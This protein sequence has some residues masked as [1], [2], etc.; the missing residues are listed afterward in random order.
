M[1][2]PCK[3][4]HQT[5]GLCL[6]IYIVSKMVQGFKVLSLTSIIAIS[7]MNLSACSP[8]IT[9]RGYIPSQEKLE[10][11][12]K[13]QDNKQTV[14][15]RLG[16]PSLT[17]SFDDQA[18]YYVSYKEER[19]AFSSQVSEQNVMEILFNITGIVQEINAYGLQ[20][21]QV[22]DLVTRKTPTQGKDLNVIQQLLSNVGRF[23]SNS[24]S[25]GRGLVGNRAPGT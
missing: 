22:I 6:M 14:L 23:N 19:N 1:F 21:G 18:W 7:L 20:D 25:T 16:T 3:S 8:I 17:G 2:D 10:S 24:S 15:G 5:I 9:Y 4:E 13:G 11:L 12:Q